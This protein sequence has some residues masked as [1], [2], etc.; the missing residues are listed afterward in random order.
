VFTVADLSTVWVDLNVYQ[1]DLGAVVAGQEVELVTDHGDRATAAIDFVQPLVGEATRTALARIEVA[2]T[3][4]HWHP[5]C[6][7]TGTVVA[8]PSQVAVRVPRDAVVALGDSGLPSVFVADEH[9][10]LARAVE[11]GRGDSR[12]VEVAA[13]LEPGERYVARGAFVLK[14]ELGRGT[15]GHGHAH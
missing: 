1:K 8:A 15:L 4:G 10:F 11:L 7:V 3:D 6:F 12:W 2:N 5:G 13:G 9:G 14:A